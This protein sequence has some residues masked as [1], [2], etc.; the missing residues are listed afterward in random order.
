MPS[1]FLP[2]SRLTLLQ[3]PVDVVEPIHQDL[4]D[5]LDV[6]VALSVT[7]AAN[8]RE[9]FVHEAMFLRY[10]GLENVEFEC[11][12]GTGQIANHHIHYHN[13]CSPTGVVSPISSCSN[14][15]R[16]KDDDCDY[17][18]GPHKALPSLIGPS[19][20][21]DIKNPVTTRQAKRWDSLAEF[22]KR[23][24]AKQVAARLIAI[25]QYEEENMTACPGMA[26]SNL[27]RPLVGANSMVPHQPDV[28]LTGL[29]TMQY[30]ITSNKAKWPMLILLPLLYGGIHLGAWEYDF[31]SKVEDVL[32]RI[33]CL[34]V[35]VLPIVQIICS[36][37]HKRHRSRLLSSHMS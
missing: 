10:Y 28:S 8:K 2:S 35:I 4:S 6:L 37:V 33:A 15:L 14:I 21:M 20:V 18:I 11:Q 1:Q 34:T 9:A 24:E 12:G 19:D 3:K 29:A 7:S 30:K 5:H 26:V 16:P 32:W 23:Y 17:M 22:L 27:L 25:G 13:C 31:P 36:W